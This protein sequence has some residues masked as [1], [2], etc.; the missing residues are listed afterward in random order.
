MRHIAL[1]ILLLVDYSIQAE[2]RITFKAKDGVT[3]TADVHMAHPSTAPF[4]ILFHQAGWSRGEYLEIAP[5]LNRIGFN[6]MAVDLRSGN[7][8]NGVRNETN[9]DAKRTMKETK[10]TDA[11]K[12]ILASV[13]VAKESYAKGKLILWGSSYSAALA[14]RYTGE[15]ID[16]VDGVLA[17][18]PGEYFKSMGKPADYIT[19]SA[20]KISCPVFITSAQ[21][22]KN[23]WWN[24]YEVI[25]S[26]D[27]TYYLPTETSGNHGSKALF[28]KFTDHQE[29]WEAVIVFLEIFKN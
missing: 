20:S 16:E 23:S 6:C 8:V 13:K 3:I 12:D 11:E 5:T 29:Y 7:L 17:F 15:H 26:E 22:E 27:K 21:N 19:Q 28:T 1:F 25:P 2:E 14:M 9:Q 4:I 18:S 10:Y 24:M